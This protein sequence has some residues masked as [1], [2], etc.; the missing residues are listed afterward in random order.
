MT[1]VAGLPVTQCQI[2]ID[3]HRSR[4]ALAGHEFSHHLPEVARH[5]GLRRVFL[6]DMG[7]VQQVDQ[8]FINICGPG[9]RGENGDRAGAE[10]S[11]EIPTVRTGETYGH[12]Q[13]IGEWDRSVKAQASSRETV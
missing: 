10:S 9:R 13:G 1:I 5:G 8:L 12:W 2:S 7:V 11:E 3:E 6:S 4:H